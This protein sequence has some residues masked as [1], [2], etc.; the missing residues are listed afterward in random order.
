M[1]EST[2]EEILSLKR[3]LTA[4]HKIEKE[5]RQLLSDVRND[6]HS[7]S[8]DDVVDEGADTEE[9]YNGN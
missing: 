5:L 1:F 4:S 8:D 6:R 2:Q 9:T 3:Q 7:D